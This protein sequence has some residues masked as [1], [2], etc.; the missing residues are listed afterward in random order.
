MSPALNRPT[1]LMTEAERLS[2][3]ENELAASSPLV[4]AGSDC[5]SP[6][7][8]EPRVA[9]QEIWFT[10]ERGHLNAVGLSDWQEAA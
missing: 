5:Q 9:M 10:C 2:R 6:P 4:C 1:P 7:A 8:G 3:P